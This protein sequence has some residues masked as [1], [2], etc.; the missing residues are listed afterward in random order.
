MTE[1]SSTTAE[2]LLAIVQRGYDEGWNRGHLDVLDDLL[3]PDFRAHDPTVPGGVVGRA[4]VSQVLRQIRAA[5]PD[6]RRE[7]LDYVGAGEKLAVRWRVTGTHQGPFGGMPPTGRP[8][9]V[10]GITF[11]HIRAGQIHEEWVELNSAGLAR[12]L[13]GG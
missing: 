3:A 11:Y 9:V 5:F 7:V 4:E 2:Q 6:V 8:V 13:A 1:H 10:T 12:Q